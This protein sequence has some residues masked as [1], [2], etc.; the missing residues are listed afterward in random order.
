MEGS[1]CPNFI[2]CHGLNTNS[3]P[4]A[5]FCAFCP[6]K[7][8]QSQKPFQT[9]CVAEWTTFLNLN[10]ALYNAGNMTYKR[11]TN[12]TPEEIEKHIGVYILNGPSPSPDI[13]MKFRQQKNE[14]VNGND[15]IHHALEPNA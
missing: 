9:F 8:P 15:A 12:F 14:Q 6:D 13:K 10:A 3:Y 7:L 1:P 5:W 4:A 11:F 2:S